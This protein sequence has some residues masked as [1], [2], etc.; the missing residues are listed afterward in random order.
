MKNN[1]FKK[2]FI[3]TILSTVLLWVSSSSYISNSFWDSWT[4]VSLRDILFGASSSYT[5]WWGAP[6][7]DCSTCNVVSV[8]DSATFNSIGLTGNTIYVLEAWNYDM[9]SLKGILRKSNVAIVWKWNVIIK[10][11]VLV[12]SN[13]FSM[14]RVNNI[15]FDNLIIDWSSIH[16]WVLINTSFWTSTNI[17]INNSTLQNTTNAISIRWWNYPLLN[18]I[19]SNNILSWNGNAIVV[20]WVSSNI[21]WLDILNNDLINNDTWVVIWWSWTPVTTISWNYF[22]GNWGD[23]ETWTNVSVV[24]NIDEVPDLFFFV[25]KTWASLSTNYSWSVA[26]TWMDDLAVILASVTAWNLY[27]NWTLKVWWTWRVSNWD[28]VKVELL[29]SPSYNTMVLS[30]LNVGWV[31]DAYSIMTLQAN[32]LSWFSFVNKTNIALNTLTVSDLVTVGNIVTWSTISITGWEYSLDSW[33]TWTWVS[34][35]LNTSSISLKVRLNSS[36]SY[37]TALSTTVTISWSNPT[38]ASTSFSITTLANTSSWWGGGGWGW[39]GGTTPTTWTLTTWTVF[40][41]NLTGLNP[42]LTLQNFMNEMAQAKEMCSSVLKEYEKINFVDIA[43]NKYKNQI[44]TLRSY[45]MV[46]WRPYKSDLAKSYFYPNNLVSR[47]E[48][49]KMLV[50]AIRVYKKELPLQDYNKDLYS[51]NRKYTDI[52][53]TKRYYSYIAYWQNIWLFDGLNM[54]GNKFYPTKYIK[55]SEA[56]LL[57]KNASKYIWIWV[58]TTTF[59]EKNS[60][61]K[62]MVADILVRN[63]GIQWDQVFLKNNSKDLKL[64]TAIYNKIKSDSLTD[65]Y[66]FLKKVYDLL[67]KI[68]S[69]RLQSV[70]FDKAALLKV[71]WESI[72]VK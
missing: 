62:W 24:P 19:I 72:G 43:W 47:A 50:N 48:F 11:T 36:P 15:I 3:L 14:D 31:T 53:K 70:W 13:V 22:T 5:Q 18:F 1:F 33:A 29:S 59:T 65:Q 46:L 64:L 37:S 44:E 41:W 54:N 61:T 52:L 63:F 6:R 20:T 4:N 10:N 42:A 56:V 28:V 40:T 27:I 21:S 35:V 45:C 12:S 60:I 57:M 32:A 58:P 55:L 71:L 38:P 51:L 26:I 17:T 9:P 49:V 66:I 8:P 30:T 68:D 39:W 34:T 25:D 67:Q 7:S 69:A 23:W 2:S 16:N